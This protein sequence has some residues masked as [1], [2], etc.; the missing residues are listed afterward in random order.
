MFVELGFFIAVPQGGML[1][2]DHMR[3]DLLVASQKYVFQGE[4]GQFPRAQLDQVGQNPA[5][6]QAAA[7]YLGGGKWQDPAGGPRI[8]ISVIGF[9]PRSGIFAVAD[10]E[11][12]RDVLD[13]PDTVLV[14]SQTRSIFGSFDTGR[15]VTINGHRV[16]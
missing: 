15:V 1:V 9:D 3:F 5:V 6:A 11:N 14:D 16:A 13:K 12:R 2:Y 7:F 8:D 10:I 4:S